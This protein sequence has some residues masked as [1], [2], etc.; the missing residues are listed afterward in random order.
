MNSESKEH[1]NCAKLLNLYKEMKTFGITSN[2]YPA[3][4]LANKTNSQTVV[5]SS[6][7]YAPPIKSLINNLQNVNVDEYF[8]LQ[9]DPN[10]FKGFGIRIRI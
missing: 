2:Y 5:A 6:S 1:T 4:E 7:P 9:I 8:S 10:Y 3:I